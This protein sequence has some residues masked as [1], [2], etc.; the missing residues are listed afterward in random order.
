MVGNS[1]QF[2]MT[3]AWLY[4]LLG[5]EIELPV[6]GMMQKLLRIVV[7][8]IFASQIVVVVLLRGHTQKL[9]PVT[10]FIGRLLVLAV[11]W[12]AVSKAAAHLLGWD[13]VLC[14]AA[15]V[16]IH[17]ALLAVAWFVLGRALGD[18]RDRTALLFSGGQKTLPATTVIATEYFGHLG[19]TV[20]PVLLFH[21][22]QLIVDSVLL[23]R[24]NK[25]QHAPEDTVPLISGD[26]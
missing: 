15:V 12:M 6:L 3:P 9:K 20:L 17:L 13:A 11:I 22:W 21:F 10:S 18:S 8:P 19:A 5:A 1:L 25:H 16:G 2:L 23:D 24:L 7:V 14:S 4:V 26:G